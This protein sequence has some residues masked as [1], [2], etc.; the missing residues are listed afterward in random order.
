MKTGQKHLWICLSLFL[1][2]INVVYAQEE[3]AESSIVELEEVTVIT[4]VEKDTFRTPNAVSVINREQ[5][6]RMNAPT[7]PRILRETE[8]VW[9]QQ[10]TVGQGSPLLRGLTGYQ[11]FPGN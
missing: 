3:A 9:A 2:S 11:A 4:R 8:G 7:T 5:I 6:E 10:T 1:I